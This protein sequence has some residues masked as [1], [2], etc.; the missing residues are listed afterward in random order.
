MSD[1]CS[2][3]G[4]DGGEAIGAAGTICSG[5]G[6][7]ACGR[8]ASSCVSGARGVNGGGAESNGYYM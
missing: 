3:G 5:A 7:G 8:A 6:S 2:A 1:R 4:D